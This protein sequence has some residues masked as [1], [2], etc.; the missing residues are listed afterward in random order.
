M[1]TPNIA[2]SSKGM[3]T[4][5]HALASEAGL[6]VL[7]TGGNAIEA[8]IAMGATLCVTYPHF[9]GLGGDAFWVIADRHGM[10][11][12]I[13][14]IGQA[15]QQAPA[16]SAAIPSRGA[17]ATL[18]TA[19]TV[20]TWHQAYAISRDVWRGQ[21]SWS[22]L[23]SRAIEYAAEGFPVT[24]S[25]HFWQTLRADELQTLP[26]FARTFAPDG[27][28]PAIGERFLQPELARSL[29]RI[30][31]FGA[32]EFYEGELAE[33]VIRGLQEAGSPLSV[34]DLGA[35]RARD[36]P[37]LRVAYRGGELVSMRP[38]TQGV[39]T[40]QIMGVLE[41]FDLAAIAE[42]SADYYHLLVEAVKCAF[43]DRDR[44]VCDPDFHAVPVDSMLSAATLDAHARTISMT[45]A[46][47]WPHV[48]RPGD[49]VYIGATDRDGHSVSVLQTIY[50]DWGSGVVAGDTGILWHNRGASFST[51]ARH[52]NALQPGKRPFHTLNPGMYLKDGQP[53]LLF[54]TQGADGQPQTLAAILTRLIDYQMDPLA[55]LARPRFLLGKTFSDSRDALKLEE[56]A[57]AAVF[58]ELSARGHDISAIP[59]QSPLAG[60]PGAIRIAT[61]GS[62]C[63]AHDPRS[64]GLALGV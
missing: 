53:H 62:A 54:G 37:P 1:Q 52:H 6:E 57:G 49:T 4:S 36:E 26:G 13:S 28:I 10:L 38:P 34:A 64:D 55:A 46:R 48:F 27:R 45:Q 60:H 33:R 17:A 11:R 7:R 44:L 30:A 14:G 21:A 59:A 25:Q 42:G 43:T 50:F 61:D 40:L 5:P 19:A 18:T 41:R 15:T 35:T 63:G 58:A 23:F 24:P 16:F 2:R 9:T 47:A 51:D 12:T 39:T 32:R 29:E 3:V 31:Q 56:D 20:D 22:S 8:A